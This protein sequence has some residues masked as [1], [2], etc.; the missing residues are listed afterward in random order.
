[1]TTLTTNTRVSTPYGVG[2]VHAPF[3][4]Q[5]D[6]GENVVRGVL[7]RLPVNDETR[8]HLN[9]SNCITPHAHLSGLWVFQES[10]LKV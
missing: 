6:K 9:K 2:Y 8:P 7:V 10:E 5:N 4:V 1:M 3:A